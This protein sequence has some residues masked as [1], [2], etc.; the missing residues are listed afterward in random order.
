MSKKNFEFV[1]SAK[2]A[3]GGSASV[4]KHTMSWVGRKLR[5]YLIYTAWVR[6]PVQTDFFL[7]DLRIGREPVVP[8]TNKLSEKCVRPG[9]ESA[10]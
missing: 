3:C 9:I 5:I 6:F 8:K 7:F 2:L 1:V 10:I 4:L